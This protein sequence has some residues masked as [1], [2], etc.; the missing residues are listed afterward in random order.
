MY[1]DNNARSGSLKMR[2]AL[3]LWGPVL[4]WMG[5][6]FTLSGQSGLGGMEG[7]Q[8]FH[9]LRKMGHV[10]EYGLLALL[11]GRALV[12]TWRARG[13]ALSRALMLRAWYLGVGICA[14]YALSDEFHQSLVPRRE[15]RM[16]DV[17]IDTLSA[18]A[19][20]GIWYI[21]K[22]RGDAKRNA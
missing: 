10:V 14:L 1:S 2:E 4:V 12:A 3:L 8:W 13:E 18:T 9:T 16:V 22:T 7:P 11:V 17:L 15:G 20:L 6:I 5:I 21:V 19:A